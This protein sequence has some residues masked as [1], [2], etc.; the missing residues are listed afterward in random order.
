MI[1]AHCEWNWTGSTM[2]IPKFQTECVCLCYCSSVRK[3]VKYCAILEIITFKEINNCVIRR[4]ENL[5]KV[6][7]CCYGNGDKADT[8]RV[9]SVVVIDGD[10]RTFTKKGYREAFSSGVNFSEALR[11]VGEVDGYNFHSKWNG[12]D[13]DAL[14]EERRKERMSEMERYGPNLGTSEGLRIR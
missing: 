5:T 14:L 6:W 9:I 13:C 2:A 11:V 1:D 4:S 10:G 7:L 8:V 3:L 12:R